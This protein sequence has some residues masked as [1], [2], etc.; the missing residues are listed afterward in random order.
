M[1]E[2]PEDVQEKVKQL[3][4][5]EQVLQQLMVQKQTFQLQLM[6]AES[7]LKELEGKT[8]AYRI[9]GNIM[10]LTKK[11]NLEKDLQE[12]KETLEL[13]ISSLEKQ[14]GK[15]REKAASLQKEVMAAIK[16]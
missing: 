14:E 12:K 16:K 1:A 13:R 9:M 8:E 6:E 15:T 5:F 11:E 3:Q 10:V 2:I 7:A 4:M